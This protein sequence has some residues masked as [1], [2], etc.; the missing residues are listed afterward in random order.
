MTAE[1]RKPRLQRL[2]ALF[3][4]SPIYFV[5]ACTHDR[6]SLLANNLVHDSFIKFG[7][8]GPEHGVWIGDYVLMPDHL[9]LFVR[10]DDSQITLASWGKSLKNCLSK[11]LRRSGAIAPHWEK[12]FFD[13]VLRSTESY[14]AKWDYVRNNPVRAGLVRRPED[15][16]YTGRIFD[17]EFTSD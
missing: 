15:W 3:V 7:Q 12:T 13:H 8:E 10:T 16:P 6:K 5:T 1:N 11:M 2:S 4:R 14:S 17:L 9:H